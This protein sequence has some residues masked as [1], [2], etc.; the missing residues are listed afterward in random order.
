MA[1]SFNDPAGGHIV[2]TS[3]LRTAYVSVMVPWYFAA[4]VVL[5]SKV[6]R[7]VYESLYHCEIN[8]L[9]YLKLIYFQ[10]SGMLG[11]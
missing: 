1:C 4:K 7:E 11:K 2:H 6:N 5:I 9:I 8:T 10:R 3:A